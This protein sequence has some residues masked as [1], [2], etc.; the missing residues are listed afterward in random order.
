[1]GHALKIPGLNKLHGKRVILASASPRRKQILETF[2]LSAE[3]V[4]STFAEDLSPAEFEDIHEYPVATATHK[5]VEVYERLVA[6]NPDDPPDLVIGADTVVLTHAKPS[7]SDVAYSEL[8][9]IQ[10]ELLEKPDSKAENL[11]MLLELNGAVCE[12]VTGV[13]VVF[14]I[15]TAPGYKIQSIEERSLVYFSDNPTYLL[16][17]YADSGEGID[18]A[19]GFAVQGLGGL[20]VRKIEGDY[21]N[22]VGFPAASF[23]RFLDLLV[24]EDDDFLEV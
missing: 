15:L 17:A 11:R 12:V 10:Q 1:M 13:T 8:P 3:I 19:G 16:E 7:T 14:P 5:A 2:G 9:Q 20:L 24:E 23:F 18:R 21:Q 4:P 22:V 6:T